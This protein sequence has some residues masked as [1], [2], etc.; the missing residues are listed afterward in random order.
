MVPAFVPWTP[1][2]PLARDLPETTLHVTSRRLTTRHS[3]A[4]LTSVV[5]WT[6]EVL[7][8]IV[9]SPSIYGKDGVA[10]SIPAG[11]STPNHKVRPGLIPG[12]FHAQRWAFGLAC[13]LRAIAALMRP[14]S[15]GSAP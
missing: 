10:G 5:V 13:H 1:C 2:R 4:S 14:R 15:A 7:A 6:R 12:L 11:G 3:T 9:N 8:G